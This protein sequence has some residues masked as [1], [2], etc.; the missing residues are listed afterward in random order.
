VIGLLRTVAALV[1][2]FPE[3]LP[4]M[5]AL[6]DAVAGS[7]SKA[8]ALDKMRRAAIAAGMRTAFDRALPGA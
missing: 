3:L 4:L 1:R 8:E 5:R 7:S 2:K 6:V